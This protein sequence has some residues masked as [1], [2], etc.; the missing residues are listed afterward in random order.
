MTQ[1]LREQISRRYF[2]NGSE[3]YEPTQLQ[4]ARQTRDETPLEFL[5]RCKVLAQQTVLC[6]AGPAVEK[7]YNE[8]PERMLLA[9]FTAGLTGTPGSQVRF[10]MPGTIEEAL[11]IAITV[12]QAEAQERRNDA[13]YLGTGIP[14]I[15][16]S[17]RQRDAT[18]KRAS[19]GALFQHVVPHEGRQRHTSTRVPTRNTRTDVSVCCYECGGIGHFARD[20][21][22]RRLR[23]DTKPAPRRRS[24]RARPQA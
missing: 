19:V 13:F 24:G 4:M 17:G 15:S 20:C 6:V 14:E 2:I 8:Q 16:P 18:H 9:S 3:M 23:M 12:A 1:T 10:P 21:V 7:I 5:Q 22:N 11:K